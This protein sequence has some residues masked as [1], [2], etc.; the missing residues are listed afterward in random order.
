M[1]DIRH[2]LVVIGEYGTSRI[3]FSVM[4]YDIK[5]T[6]IAR[7]NARDLQRHRGTADDELEMTDKCDRTGNVGWKKESACLLSLQDDVDLP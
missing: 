2:Q 7:F 5:L 3:L 6:S 1:K 4:L